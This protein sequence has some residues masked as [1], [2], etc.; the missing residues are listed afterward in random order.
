MIDIVTGVAKDVQSPQC[1]WMKVALL[2][3]DCYRS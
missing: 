2:S 1:K 3:Q